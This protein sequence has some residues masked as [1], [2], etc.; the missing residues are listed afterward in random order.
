MR[1]HSVS[2]TETR[3]LRGAIL[4]RE[5]LMM[6]GPA[7]IGKTA[8]VSQVPADLPL[9]LATRCLFLWS[10]KDLQDLLRQLIRQL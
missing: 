1:G 6:C 3:R 8:L 7:V 5:S 4:N 9:S 10:I 2:S